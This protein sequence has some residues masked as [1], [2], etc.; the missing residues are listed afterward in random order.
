[1][2]ETGPLR[3]D[4]GKRLQRLDLQVIA[5]GASTVLLDGAQV[6]EGAGATG[7]CAG[8]MGAPSGVWLGPANQNPSWR[9]TRPMQTAGCG[10]GGVVRVSARLYRS[11]FDNRWQEDLSDWVI[12]AAVDA[13]PGRELTWSLDCTL[14]GEGW[15]RLRPY[16]DWIAPWLSIAYPD[17]SVSEGQL[18]LYLVLDS[19]ASRREHGFTVDLRAVDPLWLL[20]AQE[21][22][23][24]IRARAGMKKTDLVRRILRN[25]VLTGGDGG[26]RTDPEDLGQTP[27][28][29]RRLSI[30]DLDRTFRKD[31]EWPRD[32]SRLDL[33]NEVL[34]GAGCTP[35]YSTA[36][37]A[38][39]ARRLGTE[40]ADGVYHRLGDRT[41]VRTYVANLPAGRELA[42]G[43]R[44]FSRG[45]TG[46]VVG[47]ID[48]SPKAD[49]L[50]DEVAIVNDRPE[51]GRIQRRFQ[52]R[53]GDN[54]RAV[55]A[56][57]GRRRSRRVRGRLV[58]DD[59]TADE[60]AQALA[61]QLSLRTT[62][63]TVRVLPEPDL[64][65]LHETVGLAV[66]D[67][68]GDPAANGQ[69]AVQRVHWGFTPADAVMELALGR[70]DGLE[71]IVR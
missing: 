28:P 49:R 67:R 54:P 14:A 44:P 68:N 22:A 34:Q 23:L 20:G 51:G 9:Q 27:N 57:N 55:W 5:A 37:G 25:S 60:V 13:D 43:A 50:E 8:S 39:A 1:V 56:E 30:P 65:L 12:A 17:G 33:V 4:S 46:D 36:E 3:T 16:L 42:G 7:F 26:D 62:T 10:R 66:W 6:E 18:G 59:A 64:D 15:N 70:V 19:P 11:T 31:V 24:P 45:M 32:T 41:P 38:L 47:V 2:L 48:T 40:G 52:I 63:A 61:E 29:P 58:E 21:F 53:D 35:L 69:W 71:G